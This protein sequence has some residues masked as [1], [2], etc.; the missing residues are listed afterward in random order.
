MRG[1]KKVRAT[2]RRAY[3]DS[4]GAVKPK[5]ENVIRA[6]D[7][8]TD[9]E[10]KADVCVIGTGAGGAPVAKELAEGG[11]RVVMLEEGDYFTTDDMSARH[12][13]MIISLYR[14]L[15]Q[16][17]TVGKPLILLPLGRAVGGT[18]IIN[19][20]TCFRTPASLFDSW[21]RKFGISDIDSD[22]MGPFFR[23][24]ERELNVTQT[25]ADIAGKNSTVIKRGAD[26]L[27]LSGD[28]I[29][30]NVRGCIG[31]GVC[32]AGCP[33][34][35][36]QH[37]A[38]TYVPKAW[39]AGA[40]TYTGCLARHIVVDRGRA[41][42]VVADAGGARLTV[43]AENVIVSAGTVHSPVLLK[44][45]GIGYQSGQLG[46]NLSVHPAMAMRALFD[47]EINMHE[48]VPQSYYIDEYASEGIMFEGAAIPPGLAAAP[49]PYFGVRHR[50]LMEHFP[51]LSQ[52]GIMVSDTSRGHV[53]DI[54]GNPLIRYD[55]NERD[56]AT[57]KKALTILTEIYWAAGA[58][59]VYTGLP[60]VPE[61]RAGEMAPLL[62][63]DLKAEDL[64]LTAFHPLGTCRMGT[65]WH[66]SVVDQ[67][68]NV[69]GVEGLYVSDGSVVPSSL[70][71]NPQM[72][73]MALATRLAYHLL[74][75]RPPTDEPEPESMPDP[76]VRPV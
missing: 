11:M 7:L 51:N 73:I 63:L 21:R 31:S 17:A 3:S 58:K 66:N 68:L 54:R 71:V 35:A 61:L 41:R 12:A 72:T 70:G 33:T 4:S 29:Y 40:I 57:F 18:T 55:L 36:K 19:S 15:G 75:K 8:G 50:A 52:F 49:L 64:I 59:A 27:G 44:R 10:I 26:K 5:H 6:S 62:D 9:T 42:A 69:H 14:E 13:D 65:S 2:G 56:L 60:S 48:G 1:R 25:P 16:V 67:S 20:G 53:R 23:R 45:N 30:R 24:V 43:R 39:D 76:I 37:T 22:V 47:E 32:T 74:S 34:S 38:A 46:Q 28:Y